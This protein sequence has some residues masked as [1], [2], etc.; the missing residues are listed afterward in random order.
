MSETLRIPP[1]LLAILEQ[2]RALLEQQGAVLCRAEAGRRPSWR[3]R[4]RIF[5]AESGC[6]RQHA[7][8][9]GHNDAVAGNVQRLIERWRDERRAEAQAV[10]QEQEQL[11]LEAKKRRLLRRLSVLSVGGSSYQH[12]KTVREFD[13]AFNAGPLPALAFAF[14]IGG[15]RP[16]VKVGRPTKAR[17]W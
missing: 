17:L 13:A 2:N 10:K 14:G 5:D 15:P 4:Y 16:P 7:I 9:I 3:I 11:K 12:R 8:V 6:R 1:S